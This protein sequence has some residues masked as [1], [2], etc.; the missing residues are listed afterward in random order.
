VHYRMLGLGLKPAL[1]FGGGQRNALARG[2]GHCLLFVQ[3]V[4]K[5]NCFL[6]K[7]FVVLS[8]SLTGGGG[9]WKI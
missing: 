6:G 3:K 4:V 1:G 5:S 7:D 2:I 9:Y 8:F